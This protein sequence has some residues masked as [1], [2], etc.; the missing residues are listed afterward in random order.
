MQII[1]ILVHLEEAGGR[2]MSEALNKRKVV[3]WISHSESNLHC[4][5]TVFSE[6]HVVP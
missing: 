1:S 6:Y 2:T 4:K 3:K 5:F